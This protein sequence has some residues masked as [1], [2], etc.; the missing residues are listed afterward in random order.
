MQAQFGSIAQAIPCMTKEGCAAVNCDYLGTT[1][2]KFSRVVPGPA[3]DIENPE[4]SNVP[5]K[6]EHRGPVRVR[7]VGACIR[8]LGEVVAEFVMV[9]GFCRHRDSIA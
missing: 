5:R 8:V 2:Q 9:G 1:C 6:R 4:A 3:A 7:V